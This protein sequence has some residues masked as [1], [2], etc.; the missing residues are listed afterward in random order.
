MLLLICPSQLRRENRS[1]RSTLA[2][3]AAAV[4]LPRR[5][6]QPHGE[7]M[8]GGGEP[9]A[10]RADAP[11]STSLLELPPSHQHLLPS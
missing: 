9:R 11:I 6:T 2:T 10:L 3:D 8:A 7:G 5:A 1:V 4:Q